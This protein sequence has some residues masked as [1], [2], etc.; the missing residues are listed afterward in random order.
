MTR[1][2]RVH[3]EIGGRNAF[4]RMERVKHS[5]GERPRVF[6][7][8][9][10]AS[11]GPQSRGGETSSYNHAAYSMESGDADLGNWIVVEGVEKDEMEVSS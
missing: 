11:V 5:G 4:P 9:G 6:P 3:E 2:E 7:G 1:F 8:F 10:Q